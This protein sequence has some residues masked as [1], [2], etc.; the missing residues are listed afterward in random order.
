[1]LAQSLRMLATVQ[2]WAAAVS[3]NDPVVSKVAA[4]LS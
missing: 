4:T 2:P 3:R 1:M